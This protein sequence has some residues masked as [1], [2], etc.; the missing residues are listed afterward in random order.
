M[1]GY[2]Q[3]LQDVERASLLYSHCKMS[4]GRSSCTAI[5]R[6]QKGVPLV[7][8]T[9]SYRQSSVNRVEPTH[10]AH[11]PPPWQPSPRVNIAHSGSPYLE[12]TSPWASLNNESA[13]CVMFP[14]YLELGSSSGSTL[15]PS[16]GLDSRR[17]IM[18]SASRCRLGPAS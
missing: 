14:Y 16:S 8:Q 1:Q 4:K 17:R 2:R 10:M 15:G 11:S 5:A 18:Q 9:V 3:P 7:T 6:C 12:S 13:F